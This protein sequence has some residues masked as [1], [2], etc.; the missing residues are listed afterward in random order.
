MSR[1]KTHGAIEWTM[2]YPDIP[3]ALC[4]ILFVFG[5]YALFDM[6]RN[7]FPDFT[8]RQG[9]MIGVY[10]GASSEQVEEQ[11][12]TKVE[13]FLF[14][15]N[16]VDKTKTYSF[17]QEG[18]M[19]IY[20]EVDDRVGRRE[21]QEFW[22][23]LKNDVL[24]FQQSQLP[25]EVRGIMVN[26]DFGSTAAMIL[27]VESKTRPYKDLL[28]HVKDIEA[29]FR[30]VEN[31][32][33]ISHSGAL[34]EQ[35]GI[36]I[37]NDKMAQYGISAGYLYQVLSS[38]GAIAPTG[39]LDGKI[40]DRPI[41]LKTY[42][43]TEADLAGQIIRNDGNGSIIRLK[44]IATIKREYEEPDSYVTNNGTKSIV[45]TLE[46]AEGNNIVQYGDELNERLQA[47]KS[48][49]PEDIQITRLAD[50]PEVVQNSIS[51]FMKEFGFAL[52]G[53]ILVTMLL[54]PFRIAAVAATTIPIT[55]AATLGI[56]YMVGIQ[57]D[58]VTLAALVIVLGIVVDNPI[59]IIDNHVE[60]LDQ[61]QSVWDAARDSASALF[62][63]VFIATVAIVATFFPLKL[64]L[65]GIAADFLGDFPYTIMIA[66]FLSFAIAMLVIPFINTVFIR[67]GLK[68]K[69][70]EE[71]ENDKKSMLDKIQ[72]FFNKTVEKAF[73]NWKLTLFL[74]ALSII[75]GI[76]LFTL[77][78]QQLFPKVNRNQF[79]MEI[80]LAKGYNLEKTD[81]VVKQIEKIMA[82]DDRIVNYTSFIGTSSP[83]FHTL[84]APKLPA[85][86]YAQIL[87]NT[88]S[89][90]ATL[91]ILEE[92]DTKYTEIAPEAYIR[93]KQLDMMNAPAPLEVRIFGE[94]IEVLKQVGDTIGKL[95][96]ETPEVLWVRTNFGNM[97][98]AVELDVKT[99]EAARLGLSR[100][101][102]ANAVAINMEGVNA[103]QV[104]DG[105][106]AIDVKIKT[107][108][109]NSEKI[110]DLKNLSVISPQ[111]ENVVPLR[112]VAK[113]E[114]RWTQERIVRRNGIR[115][116]TVRVDIGKEAV[117]NE[118][119]GV[120]RPK[121]E[122]LNLP[123]DVTIGYGGELEMQNENQGPM[124][125]SLSVSIVLI[126]L[127][128]LTHF[129]NFSHAFIG[130][131]SIPLSLLGA[132]SGLLLMGYP[133]GF[134]SFMGILALCGI[135]V[136]NGIILIDF[137]NELHKDE[138]MS[139]K[140]A[141][142]HAAE[143][144]MRPIFLTSA[145][146]AV[147]VIPMII[148]RSPLWG[149]LGTVICFGLLISMALTLFVLPVFYWVFLRGNEDKAVA[150]EGGDSN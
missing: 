15:F 55:I 126:F 36:Y 89:E 71:N 115:A 72:D 76:I 11:L 140:E 108:N 31:T 26:S 44:D 59:V 101:D 80:S 116:L 123:D 42:Y 60:K 104:W 8:I 20:V 130:F 30:R 27:A 84:Y 19:Y 141:A 16:E 61:G 28:E 119:L 13:E 21:T 49:L 18:M 65:P 38:E 125:I 33:K 103:T 134:T 34:S 51:H 3:L 96:E 24:I 112:Q 142:I 40:I 25:P 1:K 22:N 9:L 139:L 94:D 69:E 32:A 106:Y 41:Y 122:E 145:A 135:V 73:V 131:M 114:P 82:Q 7:E 75:L 77:T 95:A 128:L 74:G 132:V 14:S 146:A 137:A 46:M 133:F 129:E 98:N 144:R 150:N 148:S 124:A 97:Y 107:E 105:D 120:L 83:R 102:V 52:L 110:S 81:S 109:T 121:I 64:F 93:M 117:A 87:I 53:V 50:Q 37:D 12:T 78:T 57:L 45:I 68:N 149:P 86:N 66:L 56:M 67:R 5:I 136:R 17:S 54:L 39:D 85:K 29:E 4:A 35:V 70:K 47:I 147:G 90:E 92:Y 138:G 88:V 58:T 79:A 62:S 10:P 111:T 43:K 100:Q 91:E 143:R 113:I 99:E 48:K 63:S 127:L 118:V 23:K 2:K 6:P